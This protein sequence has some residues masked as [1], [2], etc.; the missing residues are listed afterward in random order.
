MNQKN[1]SQLIN[2]N[3]SKLNDAIDYAIKNNKTSLT[4]NL[5]GQQSE[6]I[7]KLKRIN[8]QGKRHI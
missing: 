5:L 8:L 7:E 1:Q 2:E 4:Q 6:L 3:I